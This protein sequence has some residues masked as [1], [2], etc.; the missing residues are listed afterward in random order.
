ML[1]QFFAARSGR[2]RLLVGL[3]LAG[4]FC[5]QC[6]PSPGN[7]PVR[8]VAKA[9][10]GDDL[11]ITAKQMEKLASSDHI[12]LLEL[13]LENYRAGY[14]TLRC[15][16][17]KQE[18]I[19]GRVSKVQEID[20][21]FRSEPFSVAMKWLKNPPTGDRVIFVDGWYKVNGASQ[22]VVRPHNEL[23]RTLAGGSVLRPPDGADAMRN[24]L[25]PISMFGFEK[26]MENLLKVYRQ[27]GKNG[28]LQQEFGGYFEVSGR[29]TIKLI[30]RLPAEADY[31]AHVTNVY[32]DL[33]HLAPIM[34][35]AFGW[36]WSEKSKAYDFICR[37][38][39]KDLRFNEELTDEDFRPSNNDI[40]GRS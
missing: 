11:G 25:R 19:R 28:D 30:R 22:M 13:C 15:T 26:A 35:E 1:K 7:D 4:I 39:Y 8:G 23:L 32:I 37:Y 27:A 6:I 2:I 9:A 14:T 40:R 31:P 33:E 16:F 20:V 24:T 29:K 5:I 21:K 18:R 34:I 38:Q 36:N 3:M 17:V 12:K 10:R